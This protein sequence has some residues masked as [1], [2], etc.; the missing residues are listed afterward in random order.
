M[1]LIDADKLRSL[2]EAASY[3]MRS[4][5]LR[6][7]DAAPTA[8]MWHDAKT[9]PPTKDGEYMTYTRTNYGRGMYGFIL[10][11]RDL[12]K[13]DDYA[14]Y[15]LRRKKDRSGWYDFDDEYGIVTADVDYWAERP[16]PPEE[17]DLRKEHD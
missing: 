10:W 12:Y 13:V 1:R 8:T 3:P 17:Q 2:V 14:F 7:I 9:D 4:E 11:T 15:H 5:M 6:M 16:E